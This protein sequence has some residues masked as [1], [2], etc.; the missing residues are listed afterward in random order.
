[1]YLEKT[2]L[3]YKLHIL[4][5]V[6]PKDAPDTLIFYKKCPDIEKNSE[7]DDNEYSLTKSQEEELDKLVSDIEKLLKEP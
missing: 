1:M 7:D 6:C 4:I 2:E 3:L 5:Y